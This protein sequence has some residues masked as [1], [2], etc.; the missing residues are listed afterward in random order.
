MNITQQFSF[1]RFINCL[2]LD[3]ALNSKKYVIF[4]LVMVFVLFV[5]NVFIVWTYVLSEIRD[6]GEQVSILRSYT[7]WPFFY[8]GLIGFMVLVIGSSFP[9]FR[10]KGGTVGYLQV[11]AAA[12][13][14]FI[15]QFIIRVLCA[16]SVY[17]VLMW[18]G[19]MLA[20]MVYKWIKIR[21][22]ILV[23]VESFGFFPEEINALDKWAIVL[24]LFSLAG[25]CFAC[26]VH[27]KKYAILKGVLVFGILIFM[28]WILSVVLSHILLPN[29]VNGF[30]F[31]IF[32]RYLSNELNTIKVFVYAIGIFSSI[33]LFPYAYFKLKEKEG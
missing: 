1:K 4:I 23:V 8:T 24:S 32:S 12:P 14:K 30:E 15:S 25:F 29:E 26:A 22:G 10:N 2:K 6:N 31:Q 18:L 16:I 17:V 27:F 11:P 33:F 5:A 28:A 9:M 21:A 20:I 13:E 19:R 7:F 3:I